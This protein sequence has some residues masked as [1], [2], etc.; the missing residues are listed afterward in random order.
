[1]C[2]WNCFYR[3]EFFKFKFG[4]LVTSLA[5][6]F[7][8]VYFGCVSTA[9]QLFR[10]KIQHIYLICLLNVQYTCRSYPKKAKIISLLF[11][12]GH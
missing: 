4:A 7:N 8:Y 5:L 12:N 2:V 6:Y 11:L 3:F 10:F 1:M 9:R